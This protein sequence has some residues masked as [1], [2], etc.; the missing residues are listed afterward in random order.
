VRDAVRPQRH[1]FHG[2]EIYKGVRSSY[3][4][5]DLVGLGAVDPGFRNDCQLLFELEI[6]RSALRRIDRYPVFIEDCRTVP[7]AGEAHEAI[8]RR[9]AALCAE[10]GTAV[11]CDGE[12]VWIDAP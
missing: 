4:A 7:A 6:T 12:R 9:I 1:V 8:V 2:I 3:S 5:G 11:Q 10:M